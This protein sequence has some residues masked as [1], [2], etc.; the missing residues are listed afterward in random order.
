MGAE[1]RVRCWAGAL[2]I[3][4]GA[5][6][7][8]P[9]WADAYGDV[10]QLASRGESAAALS[11][12]DGYIKEHPGDPQMRF[13]KAGILSNIGRTQDAQTLLEALTQQYPELAE[14]WN[15][16]AVIYAAQ[17]ELGKARSALRSAL[18]IRP[19]YATALENLG[20]VQV[21]EALQSYERAHQLDP[22]NTRLAPKISQ[23]QAVVPVAPKPAK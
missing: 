6:W 2:L 12:A 19:D 23:L 9:V 8:A 21:R 20:D 14:P 10:Q 18:R 1:K 17:G 11:K 16:L 15:N 3:A 4:L 5:A 22:A 7:A 13:I